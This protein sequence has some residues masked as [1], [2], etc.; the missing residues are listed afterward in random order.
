MP[1]EPKKPGISVPHQ[2]REPLY[3]CC[4]LFWLAIAHNTGS[5]KYLIKKNTIF[6]L[7]SLLKIE[8]EITSH[9]TTKYLCKSSSLG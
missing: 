6:L 8:I 5:P 4:Q 7:F 3:F 9:C 1:G 2:A